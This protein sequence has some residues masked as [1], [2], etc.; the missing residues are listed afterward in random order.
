MEKQHI[1]AIIQRSTQAFK[2]QIALRQK[3]QDQWQS[4]SYAELGSD[5]RTVARA[6]LALDVQP[7]DRIGIFSQNRP[8]WTYADLGTL[9][10]RGVVVPIYATNTAQQAAYIINE[11]EMNVLFVDSQENYDKVQSLREQ[12]P[13]LTT[14]IVFNSGV[15]ID[16]SNS[17]LF[18][19]FLQ[20]GK[21]SEQDDQ[22]AARLT[23]AQSDDLATIIY[24]SGTT[25][26][27]KGAMLT[28][29]NL[30]HQFLALDSEF[31]VGPGDRSL[32][33]LP[34]SHVYERVWSYYVYRV[35]AEN[36]YLSNPR[37]VID[38]MQ[39]IKPT[40]MV[41]V[42]R[43]YEKV[44]AAVHN[45]LESGSALKKK[46][47]HWAIDVGSAYQYLLKD[48]KP[49]GALLKL[50]HGLAD[51]LVLS[52]VREAVGGSKNFFSAGGAPLAQV[53]E[54]FFFA[55]GLLVCQGY[56]LTECS[57]MVSFNTPNAFKFGTVGKLVPNCEVKITDDGEILVKG[58]NVMQGYFKK[59]KETAVSI[60]DG[61]FYTG[62]IGEFDKD[63]FLRITDRIK[64]LIITSGGKN[65]APQRIE[66]VVSKDHFIEQFIAI[67]DRRKY[68]SALIVP[69]FAALEEFAKSEKIP[70]ATMEALIQHPKVV[71]FYQARIDAHSEELAEYERIKRFT[72]LSAP[73]VQETGELTPTQKIKRKVVAENYKALIDAMYPEEN[74]P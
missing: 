13:N 66:T 26:E 70:V 35:G 69:N 40:V 1:A 7:G 38:T 36:N 61:W 55:T 50:K 2:D 37:A 9:T 71:A 42:P 4:R 34:L 6:L 8:K 48:K 28:H 56:G 45:G 49:V 65:I 23:E 46:L 63:G 5:I 74:L 29:A 64:N 51:K 25:G 43:L 10:V 44:Y 58:P 53:I 16:E 27:P 12:F 73:F 59:E 15:T 41:S 57:P 24:T 20:T 30:Y 47:F 67:G 14:V 3:Q 32:C 39:E 18:D 19:T 60:K 52:K 54:E 11:T 62:D 31:K 21:S 22:L 33:F 72:L 68:I 17:Q